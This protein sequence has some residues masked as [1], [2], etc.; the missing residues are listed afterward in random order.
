MCKLLVTPP[1]SAVSRAVEQRLENRPVLDL[2]YLIGSISGT[3]VAPKRLIC[4]E[5]FQLWMD[6]CQNKLHCMCL[7]AHPREQV[8]M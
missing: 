5:E 1:G 6:L 8:F 3:G 2:E 4:H 7:Y